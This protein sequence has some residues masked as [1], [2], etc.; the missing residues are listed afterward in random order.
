MS[1]ILKEIVEYDSNQLEILMKKV[2][3]TLGSKLEGLL[4]QQQNILDKSE[5][6]KQLKSLQIE[7]NEYRKEKTKR[8]NELS[9]KKLEATKILLENINPI[10]S[11]YADKNSISILMQKKDIVIG[12]SNLDKT[13]EILKIIDKKLTKIN[14]N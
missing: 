4:Y 13:D 5:L 3:F 10:L 12:K 7:A 1:K 2:A 14:F 8:I 9:K 11:E 6:E